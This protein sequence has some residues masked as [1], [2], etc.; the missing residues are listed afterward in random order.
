MTQFVCLFGCVSLFLHAP[1]DGEG[2]R[3]CRNLSEANKEAGVCFR[4]GDLD[5]IRRT[6]LIKSDTGYS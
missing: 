3:N 2:K 5:G 4:R 1:L 6:R